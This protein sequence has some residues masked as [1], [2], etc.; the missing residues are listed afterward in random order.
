MN[1]H[2]RH[3]GRLTAL[4][5]VI[6]AAACSGAGSK[7][8]DTTHSSQSAATAG[9]SAGMIAQNLTKFDTLDFNIFS[10]QQFDRFKERHAEDITVTWPDGHDTHGLSKHI[11]DMKAWDNQTYMKQLGLA[12]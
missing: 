1:T 11:E 6:G 3:A 10:H 7:P 2:L 9:D 12:P 8:A 5:I 4:A